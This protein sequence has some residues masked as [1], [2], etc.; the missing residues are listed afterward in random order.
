M[1]TE[2]NSFLIKPCPL[3]KKMKYFIEL[4]FLFSVK[5]VLKTEF[6]KFQ[7]IDINEL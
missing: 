6:Y 4:L 2:K 5:T 7:S 1:L 3:N